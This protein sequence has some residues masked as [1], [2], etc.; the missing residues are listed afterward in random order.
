MLVFAAIATPKGRKKGMVYV[1]NKLFFL[2][3][4]TTFL[5]IDS[6]INPF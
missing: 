2:A 1:K 4:N 5:E 3:L 6:K